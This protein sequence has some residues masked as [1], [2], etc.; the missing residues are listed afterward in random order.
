M[1]WIWCQEWHGVS[2]ANLI[3]EP[4]LPYSFL[5]WKDSQDLVPDPQG[6]RYTIRS[7]GSGS[8]ALDIPPALD[9]AEAPTSTTGTT[10]TGTIPPTTVTTTLSSCPTARFSNCR[11]TLCCHLIEFGWVTGFLLLLGWFCDS[12]I[13]RF[14]CSASQ[15]S[16]DPASRSSRGSNQRMCATR[17]TSTMLNAG[18]QVNAHQAPEANSWPV[19]LETQVLWCNPLEPRWFDGAVLTDKSGTLMIWWFDECESNVDHKW[20]WTVLQWAFF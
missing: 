7:S 1:V 19:D 18:N 14:S 3:G 5:I 13:P 17:R 12:F 4:F 11:Q 8:V 2:T 16:H 9:G 20:F 10:G 6:A 15:Q